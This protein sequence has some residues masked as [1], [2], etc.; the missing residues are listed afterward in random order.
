M[1]EER[2]AAGGV[3]EPRI[4]GRVEGWKGKREDAMAVALLGGKKGEGVAMVSTVGTLLFQFLDEVPMMIMKQ[5]SHQPSLGAWRAH[6]AFAVRARR[7]GTPP[8]TRS[9]EL[10]ACTGTTCCDKQFPNR[11]VPNHLKNQRRGDRQQ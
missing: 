6:K 8:T 5:E 1:S 11:R 4:D 10:E 2:K 9:L 7:S 3:P